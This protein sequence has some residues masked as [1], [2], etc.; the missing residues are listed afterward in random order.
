MA[1]SVACYHGEPHDGLGG[2]TP[3]GVWADKAAEQGTPRTVTD[4]TA[5]LV[6]F[7]P[8]ERRTLTRSGFRLDHV[9][10]YSDAL[11][12]FI[13]RR[14]QP[15]RFVLRRDPR[16]I[17]RIWVL[18]P[19]SGEYLQVPY[20]TWS[21]PAISVWEQTAAVA[22]LREQGRAEVDEDALFAMV[23]QMRHITDIATKSSR[24]ARRDGQRRRDNTLVR[25][26]PYP[27][28][29]APPPDSVPGS[30]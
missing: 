24:K 11:K 4:E 21:R 12:P 25:P 2:R 27:V 22:R 1:L 13:G 14:D 16:D 9:Q 15:E 5:F 30:V 28:V 23:E 7:L 26:S 10:Y 18:D 19:D 17:S 8:V 3:A 6:D 29:P 20:R